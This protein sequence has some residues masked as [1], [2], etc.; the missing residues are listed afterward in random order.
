MEKAYNFEELGRRAMLR[1]PMSENEAAA[2]TEHLHLAALMNV[3][4]FDFAEIERRAGILPEDCGADDPHVR[5]AKEQRDLLERR[6]RE[7]RFARPE[8]PQQEAWKTYG[9]P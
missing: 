9:Q 7:S 4:E 1:Q 3:K 5:A 2:L 8:P 6:R